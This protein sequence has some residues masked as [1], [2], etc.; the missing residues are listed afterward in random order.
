MTRSGT[1]GRSGGRIRPA[2]RQATDDAET[3]GADI[4]ISEEH[5]ANVKE[6]NALERKVKTLREHCNRLKRY[7]EWLK[8]NYPQ[9]VSD[10][11]V[12]DLT[13]EELSNPDLFFYKMTQDLDYKGFNTKIFE[14]FLGVTKTKANGRICSHEHIRKFVDAVK[15][16]AEQRNH[17]LPREFYAKTE[18]SNGAHK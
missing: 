12:K 3:I 8:E 4:E 6:T 18:R 15:W 2:D 7:A 13:E 1:G 11:G 14:A 10:G 9:Y 17:L 5:Q 16:G